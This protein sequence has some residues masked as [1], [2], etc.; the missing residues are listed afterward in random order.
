[1][2]TQTARL[3]VMACRVAPLRKCLLS[4]RSL[5]GQEQACN[6]H[7]CFL[8]EMKASANEWPKHGSTVCVFLFFVDSSEDGVFVG[9]SEDGNELT[10]NDAPKLHCIS[11]TA[12]KRHLSGAWHWFPALNSTRELL[13]ST[14]QLVETILL[15][16]VRISPNVNS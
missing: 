5:N 7:L 8:Q 13:P 4:R 3:I 16:K 9:S 6:Q 2:Q 11:Q 14:H 15:T 1:M 10:L 12:L